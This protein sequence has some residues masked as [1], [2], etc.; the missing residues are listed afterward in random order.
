MLGGREERHF[1]TRLLYMR[2]LIYQTMCLQKYLRHLSA[3]QH[4]EMRKTNGMKKNL[5]SVYKLWFHDRM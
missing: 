4:F 5:Q 2:K 3:R 1:L